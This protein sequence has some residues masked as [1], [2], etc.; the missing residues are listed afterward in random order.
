MTAGGT[1]GGY[2]IT[3]STGANTVTFS[4][5]NK[6]GVT[7]VADGSNNSA[8]RALMATLSGAPGTGTTVVVM[9]YAYLN[10]GT[11]ATP[12]ITGTAITGTVTPITSV[13]PGNHY[14]EWTFWANGSAGTSVIASFG[15]TT[16]TD[17]EIDAIAMSGT[18]TSAPISQNKTNGPTT[19]TT[20][21]AILTTAL[22][23]GDMEVAF[24]GTAGSD[25]VEREPR[26]SVGRKSRLKT[27]M[28]PATAWARIHGYERL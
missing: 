24:F 18:N 5:T 9:V 3:A 15:A 1:S 19:N 8:G 27:A 2:N 14:E 20:P 12:N 22:P 11:P 13:S 21:T 7:E 16:M 26:P 6:K 25:H 4:E 23:P 17:I 28:S 10:G